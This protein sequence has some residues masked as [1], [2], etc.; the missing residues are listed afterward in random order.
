GETQGRPYLVMDF[1]EG[2]SLASSLVDGP[3]P[4]NRIVAIARSLAGALASLHR[5]GLVHRDLKPQNV[6]LDPVGS[7]RLIDFGFATP[8]IADLGNVEVVGTLLYS[9]PEQTGLLK[10]PI[11]GRS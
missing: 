3:L 11:D 1:V 4:E 8:T 6:I 5:H 7:A 2:R 9:A 10:R